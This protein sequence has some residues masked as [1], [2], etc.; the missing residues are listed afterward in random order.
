MAGRHAQA[1]QFSVGA[2]FVCT[3]PVDVAEATIVRPGELPFGPPLHNECYEADLI[4]VA[5]KESWSDTP[6]P[7]DTV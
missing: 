1:G 5:P 2:C 3:F 7:L 4:R 6:D